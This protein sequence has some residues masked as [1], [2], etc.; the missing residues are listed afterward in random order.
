M[1]L[2][3]NLWGAV[4]ARDTGGCHAQGDAA[5]TLREPQ[6]TCLERVC[7]PRTPTSRTR[8]VLSARTAK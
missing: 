3:A 8:W 1:G 7:A 2:R 5:P 6:L 4:Q